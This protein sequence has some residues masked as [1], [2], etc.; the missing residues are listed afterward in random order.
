[1]KLKKLKKSKQQNTNT[2]TNMNNSFYLKNWAMRKWVG[3]WFPGKR[4]NSSKKLPFKDVFFLSSFAFSSAF[5]KA[6]L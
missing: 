4:Y 2:S 3:S 1:M 6:I 5:H